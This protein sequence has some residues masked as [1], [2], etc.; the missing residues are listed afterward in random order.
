MAWQAGS[1]HPG[2]IQAVRI[3]P[4]RSHP[5]RSIQDPASGTPASH[6]EFVWEG[7]TMSSQEQPG[8]CLAAGSSHPVAMQAVRIQP[9]RSQP[10]SRIQDTA[11]GKPAFSVES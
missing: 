3:Q 9:S 10:G 6:I 7:A 5:G 1:S 2:A 11:S 8:V 4:S